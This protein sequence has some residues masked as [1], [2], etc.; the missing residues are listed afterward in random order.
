VTLPYSG[1]N[2]EFSLVRWNL[3]MNVFDGRR[4][5][6]PDVPVQLTAK[7]YFAGRDPALDAVFRLIDDG[8]RSAVR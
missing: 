2:G 7:D 1:T 3:S 4:E 8:K 6:S 5:M